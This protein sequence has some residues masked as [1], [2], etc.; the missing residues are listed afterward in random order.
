MVRVTFELDPPASVGI[1]ASLA[2]TGLPDGPAFVRPTIASAEGG[3]AVLDFPDANWGADVTM[4]ISALV[5]GEWAD[6][7][8]FTRCRVL[9][10]EWPATIG[11]GPSFG[12]SRGV[13]VGAIVKP[14]LGLAPHELAETVSALARGGADLVKDDEL[15]GDPKWCRLED[16]VRAVTA[17]AP[18][19]V[20]YAPNVTGPSERLVTRAERVVELGAR[21][22]MVNAFAQG[23]DAIRLLRQSDLGVP[24]FAH[25]VGAALWTRRDVG[26]S[27][28]VLTELTRLCG[29]DFVQV[30]SFTGKLRDDVVAVRA[31]LAACRAPLPGG[32]RPSVAVLS[33]GVAPDNAAGELKRAGVRDGVMVMLGSAAYLHPGGP[34]EAVRETVEAV[35]AA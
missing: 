35:R 24:I 27:A 14:S 20:I 10:V 15:L 21:A 11:P 2:S 18:P 16:R 32:A 17:L 28:A 5:A 12:A 8:A 19:E 6:V 31:Q 7:A 26:V 1:L 3:R 22:V 13:R 33:G 23:L 29:A 9:K 30:G 4:L 25:R 34:E